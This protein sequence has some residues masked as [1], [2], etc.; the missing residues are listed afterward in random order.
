MPRTHQFDPGA[1][2]EG[3]PYRFQR[4]EFLALTTTP[5]LAVVRCSSPPLLL[6]GCCTRTRPP[7]PGLLLFPHLYCYSNSQEW[8]LG[9]SKMRSVSKPVR[10]S[11]PGLPRYDR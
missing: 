10:L 3:R 6:F 4:A 8:D 11:A 9:V 7:P 5:L 2:A 1:A